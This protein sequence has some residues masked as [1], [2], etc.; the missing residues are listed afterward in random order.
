MSSSQ[1]TPE[2]HHSRR[3]L[4]D[5]MLGRLARWLRILGYDTLYDSRWPDN[6]LVRLSRA[7]DRVLLTRD[8]ALA[9]RRGVRTLLVT[10]DRVESQLVQVVSELGLSV[11]A[12]FMRCPVCNEVLEEVPRSWA[13]GYV[14]PYTFCTQREF[15]LCPN[16]DRFYW[17]GTHW[18]QM[19]KAMAG[20]RKEE[21]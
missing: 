4:A 19:W 13:W 1:P 15:R 3:L 8:T 17:R 9:R 18:E 2:A 11:R 21:A 6:E 12:A 10:A 5:A 20:L 16:C 14:P 7:E